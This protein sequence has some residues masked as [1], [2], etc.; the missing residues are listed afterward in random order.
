MQEIKFKGLNH[1][2]SIFI[3]NNTIN[4]LPRK[5]KSIC[6]NTKKIALIIDSKIPSKF[7]KEIDTFFD[8]FHFEISVRHSLYKL[9]L[10]I[11]E[12]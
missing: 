6:P 7:K 10:R 1:N 3:G 2:Y 4:L 8:S 11:H 5:I 12:M 9:S